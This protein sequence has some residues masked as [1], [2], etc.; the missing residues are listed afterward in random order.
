RPGGDRPL[1][2]KALR[3]TRRRAMWLVQGPLRHLVA[4]R[5]RV[6]R[7]DG[8]GRVS[9]ADRPPDPGHV[10]HEEARPR[11][12]GTRLPRK[13]STRKAAPEGILPFEPGRMLWGGCRPLLAL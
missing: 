12:A 9:R 10:P 13:V 8:A 4:D 2:G 1:L 6:P 5:S 11:R 3:R 7:S